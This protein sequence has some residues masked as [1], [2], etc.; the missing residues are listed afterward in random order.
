MR[1]WAAPETMY[2]QTQAIERGM[3]PWERL[4]LGNLRECLKSKSATPRT[5]MEATLAD[6][7]F[8]PPS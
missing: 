6:H 3:Q 1:A 2:A 8:P 7:R 4:P 5:S